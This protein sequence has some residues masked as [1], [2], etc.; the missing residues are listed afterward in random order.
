MKNKTKSEA[1]AHLNGFLYAISSLSG[2]LRDYECCS[3]FV[4]IKDESRSICDLINEYYNGQ[5]E[6]VF[7]SS[8]KIQHDLRYFENQIRL[9]LIRDQKCVI[10][11]RIIDLQRYLSFRLMDMIDE[12]FR[13]EISNL[14]VF[15]LHEEDLT[16]SQGS[17][18][19]CILSD[20][21][22]LVLQF[23]DFR[24]SRKPSIL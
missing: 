21:L 2:D 10:A 13:G 15:E 7:E 18:F 23:N 9:Y 12:I 24:T 3:F 8:D 11:D 1:V 22:L 5:Y 20:K 17:T 4:E 16:F 14:R 19:F 6:F